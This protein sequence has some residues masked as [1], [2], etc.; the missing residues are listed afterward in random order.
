MCVYITQPSCNNYMV[1][2]QTM[3]SPDL[4]S[5]KMSLCS[6]RTIHGMFQ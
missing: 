4:Q 3:L 1:Y 5:L 2:S 6:T